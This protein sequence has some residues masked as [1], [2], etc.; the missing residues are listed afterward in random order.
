M[1]LTE[2]IVQKAYTED[3]IFSEVYTALIDKKDAAIVLEML[4]NDLP[5][6]NY[7]LNHLKR[8][9]PFDRSNKA[10]P[11]QIVI[12]PVNRFAEIPQHVQE[13]CSN[14]LIVKVCCVAPACRQEFEAWNKNWPINFHASHL[15][16]EREKGLCKQDLDQAEAAFQCL[17]VDERENR[18]GGA[19]MLNPDN[20]KIVSTASEALT[21]LKSR[22]TGVG[23]EWD[24]TA[25]SS[26]YTPTMLCIDGVAGVVRG[27]VPV[28]GI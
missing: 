21:A 9:Q 7:G 23:K 18:L 12:C 8:I 11:L 25:C 22:V 28:R 6:Q 2:V 1:I 14:R 4:C 16:K 19:V 27:D 10:G 5:L 24:D 26:V 13:I 17:E 3:E 15:E 20:G